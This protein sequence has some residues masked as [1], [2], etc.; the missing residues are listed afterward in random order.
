MGLTVYGQSGSRAVRALWMV[1]ELGVPYEHN[2]LKFA[3]A[4]ETPDLLALNPYGR[5]PAIS[6]DGFAVFESMAINLYLARRFGGPLAPADLKEEA[7]AAQWSFFVMTEIEKTL[8]NA[9]CYARGLFN[10]PVDPEKSKRLGDSLGRA[11]TALD[12]ALE[13]RAYLLGDR[14]TVADIN[15]AGVLLWAPMARLDLSGY[16]R[17]DDWLSRCLSRDALARAQAKP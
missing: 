17:L 5:V 12:R 1:E 13:G 7:Q 2:A 8:L 10:L 14:F 3:D 9:L 16:P 4:G 15:A 11:F 6:D